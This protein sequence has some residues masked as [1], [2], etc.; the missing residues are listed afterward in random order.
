MS[1]K[2]WQVAAGSEGRDRGYEKFF[3]RHGMAFV[4]PGYEAMQQIDVGDIVLLKR[5]S[6]E[7]VT[8]GEVVQ[9]NGVHRGEGGKEWLQDF[10]GWDLSAY[11]YVNWR[12]PPNPA[13][14]EPKAE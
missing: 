9:R 14:P 5:G 7:I 8:A 12:V 3:L 11:C 4:G 1:K 2:Y 6:S 13:K 10:D